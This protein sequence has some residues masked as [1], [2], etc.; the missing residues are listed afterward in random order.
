MNRLQQLSAEYSWILNRCRHR[1]ACALA[2]TLAFRVLNLVLLAPVAAAILRFG[3]SR[4]G[5]ASV[6]NF[7]MLSF[8]LTPEGLAALLGVGTILLASTYLELAG[9]L[10]LLAN[11]RLH[12]WEAFRSSTRLFLHLVQLGLRQLLVYLVLL[13]P[14]A[15]AIGL[16]Y[17][18]LWSGKDLNGLIVLKPPAYWW[19]AGLAAVFAGS[20]AA[21]VAWFFLRWLYAVPILC[22]EPVV[23]VTTALR[24]SALRSRGQLLPAAL[25]L[26]VWLASAAILVLAVYSASDFLSEEILRFS[27]WNM[28]TSVLATGLVL[29]ANA[30]VAVTISVLANL[31]FAGVILALYRH[32]APPDALVHQPVA[33]DHQRL[34]MGWL[35]GTALASAGLLSSIGSFLAIVDL[36]VA[37][38][39]EITAHR[40]GA[41]HAPENTIAA[42]KQA[43]IDK[44]DWAEIDVQNTADGKLVVMHDIDLARLGGGKRRVD[45]ATLAEIQ[46]FDVGQQF[47]PA[48]AGERIATLADFLTAMGDNIRLNIE[49]KPHN[50]RDAKLLTQRVIEQ[51]QQAGQVDRCRI[52]SQSYESLQLARQLEPKLPVGYIVAT[53]LG[54]PEKL[55]VDF[56]MVKTSL[57]KRQLVDRANS[58]KIAVHAWTVNQPN[59]VAPL[60]DAGVTNLITDDPLLIRREL[61]EIR[62]LDT[63]QRLLLRARNEI[64]Q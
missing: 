24:Q 22:L 59:S 41:T 36:Q 47:S 18:L 4:W 39:V 54:S 44:A 56:L 14:F 45:Q 60:L 42:L 21:V 37:E 29:L 61:D 30:I 50:S 49:L 26:G 35:M 7:E 27:S 43:I 8:A 64:L 28:S 13:I 46:Q 63:V 51:V 6:G 53:S 16:T 48:F 20:Y 5:R 1:F 3:L 58:R 52:C 32:V 33:E 10:R 55:N 34:S 40:A 25:M 11:D 31:T 9:L 2:F 19:G 57:A 12:W 15:A 38:Q 17:W 23:S 62:G